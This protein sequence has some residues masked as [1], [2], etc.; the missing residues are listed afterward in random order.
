MKV[1]PE[2]VYQFL[3]PCLSGVFGV[4]LSA[5]VLVHLLEVDDGVGD[6]PSEEALPP[7]CL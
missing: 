6:A 2:F 7:N 3:G 1:S 5:A 4:L